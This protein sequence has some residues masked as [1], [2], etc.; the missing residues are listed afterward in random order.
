MNDQWS[1]KTYRSAFRTNGAVPERSSRKRTVPRIT[2]WPFGSGRPTTTGRPGRRSSRQPAGARRDR[3]GAVARD[4]AGRRGRG[5]QGRSQCRPRR[6]GAE[7]EQ[8]LPRQALAALLD[9][10]DEILLVPLVLARLR[11]VLLELLLRHQPLAGDDQR[12]REQSEG[13]P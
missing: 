13:K 7:Y 3:R 9:Q 1:G 2:T 11:V 6:A 5:V 4:R 8:A 12:R 10:P